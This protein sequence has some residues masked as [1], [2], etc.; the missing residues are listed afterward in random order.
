MR[1]AK[2]LKHLREKNCISLRNLAKEISVPHTQIHAIEMGSIVNPG[3]STVIS[4]AN[5]FEVSIDD[6]VN[7]DF[8]EK[9]DK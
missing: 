6:L 9:E 3:I 8:S 4:I 5:Y 1:L 7:S 2:N